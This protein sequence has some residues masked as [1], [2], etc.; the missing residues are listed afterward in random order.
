MARSKWTEDYFR[1]RIKLERERRRMTQQDLVKA[2]KT[3][4]IELHET[5]IAKIERGDRSV[6]IDEASAVADVFGISLDALLGRRARPKSDRVHVLTAVADTAIRST[7]QILDIADAVRDRIADLSP[8]DDD[9]AAREDLIAGCERA[10]EL[11]V[12]ANDALADTGQ[13]ARHAVR[14]EVKPK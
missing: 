9:L 5:T 4:G 10:Y 7:G 2:L 6:R 14:D 12:A 1:K 3:K 8:P 13:A 11:L